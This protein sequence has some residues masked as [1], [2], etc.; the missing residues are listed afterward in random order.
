MSFTS[1]MI[2]RFLLIASEVWRRATT[3]LEDLK[4]KLSNLSQELRSTEALALMG[5][6]ITFLPVPLQEV[7]QKAESRAFCA[8]SEQTLIFC[9]DWRKMF[10]PLSCAASTTICTK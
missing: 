3:L 8:P 10:K 7:V 1:S 6:F 5:R 2:V 4:K 9:L